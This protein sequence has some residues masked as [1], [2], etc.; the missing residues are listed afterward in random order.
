MFRHRS[1]TKRRMKMINYAALSS[2]DLA[3]YAERDP[4]FNTDPLFTALAERVSRAGGEIPRPHL[5][6]Y[7]EV[8]RCA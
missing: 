2:K 8:P 1:I 6:T 7:G 4:R 3:S 5:N